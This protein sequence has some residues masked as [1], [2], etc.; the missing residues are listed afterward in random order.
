ML[1][2][3]GEQLETVGAGLEHPRH[4]RRDANRVEAVDLEDVVVELYPAGAGDDDVDLLGVLVAVGE[5]L[6]LAGLD[7]V[8]GEADR[9]AAEVLARKRRL[10][11][12]G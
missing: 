8:E 9:L 12:F 5:A 10:P 3:E 2:P 1:G 7:P 4:L 6:A 11:L